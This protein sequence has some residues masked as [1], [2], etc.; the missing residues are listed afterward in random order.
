M[1]AGALASVLGAVAAGGCVTVAP[2]AT[3]LASIDKPREP[4]AATAGP[5]REVRYYRDESGALW[6]DRGRRV[7]TPP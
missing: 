4:P 1:A 6:D 3:P 5:E 2:P 7:P